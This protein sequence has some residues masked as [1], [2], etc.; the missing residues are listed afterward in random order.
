MQGSKSTHAS[1]FQ[2]TA[3]NQVY[4]LFLVIVTVGLFLSQLF[5]IIQADYNSA[6][7]RETILRERTLKL[8]QTLR[9][10]ETL[11]VLIAHEYLNAG[12]SADHAACEMRRVLLLK[13][14]QDHNQ[15]LTMALSYIGVYN[16]LEKDQSKE[17]SAYINGLQNDLIEV[18][19]SQTRSRWEYTDLAPWY[20]RVWLQRPEDVMSSTLLTSFDNTEPLIYGDNELKWLLCPLMRPTQ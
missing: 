7:R 16:I 20:L 17:F 15:L 9:E 3:M 5:S 14:P 4:A 1:F 6:K 8:R 19:A 13:S 12:R 2:W 18:E 11:I 10:H